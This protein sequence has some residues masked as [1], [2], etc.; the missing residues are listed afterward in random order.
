MATAL[1]LVLHNG[2]LHTLTLADDNDY[3]I[4]IMLTAAFMGFI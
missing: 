4:Y 3:Y 1:T 2:L